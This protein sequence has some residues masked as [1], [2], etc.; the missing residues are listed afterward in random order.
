VSPPP[1]LKR[2][3]SPVGSYN[4]SSTE[5]LQYLKYMARARISEFESYMPSHA[6]VS[7]RT[8]SSTIFLGRA[9]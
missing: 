9:T 1:Q 4:P 6:V 7:S 2:E 8:R 5:L 3:W